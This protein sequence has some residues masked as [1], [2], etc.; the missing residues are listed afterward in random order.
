MQ[1]FFLESG[2]D[3]IE[4]LSN[5]AIECDDYI[6]SG[7]RGWFT[8]NSMQ[9][10]SQNV[11]YS[12]IINRETIR[13]RM[14]LECARQIREKTGKE[15][16]TFL[17]F[18]PIWSDFRCDEIIALLEEYNIKQCYFGHIHSCY[19]VPSS[20]IDG[21]IKFSIIS[22]DYLDFIPQFIG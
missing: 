16:L 17:H 18:P 21:N 14:S 1:K 9:T 10:A 12:K 15:I 4:I 13:L 7:S 6:I 8:D 19:T 3:S 11:D 22:A 20:F 5:N 2:I